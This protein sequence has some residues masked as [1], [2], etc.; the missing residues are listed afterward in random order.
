MP[1]TEPLA[2]VTGM[3]NTVAVPRVADL[4][5]ALGADAMV[6]DAYNV[7][8]DLCLTRGQLERSETHFDGAAAAGAFVGDGFR[9]LARAYE[10]TDR[11]YDAARANA[12]A[13]KHGG[14]V[15]LPT[16]RLLENVWQG[17]LEGN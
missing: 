16:Q 17:L 10:A 9:D 4:L 3:L 13:I 5:A 11:H 14:D 6:A 8:G 15:A 2:P 1:R 7:L 12:K